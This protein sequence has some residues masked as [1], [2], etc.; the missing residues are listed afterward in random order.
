MR[1]KGLSMQEFAWLE[2][3]VGRGPWGCFGEKP[4]GRNHVLFV[5]F[6]GFLLVSLTNIHSKCAS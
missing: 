3:L 5:A 2:G 1:R 6:A 4:E